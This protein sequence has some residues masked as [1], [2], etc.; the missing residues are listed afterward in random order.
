MAYTF[1]A[2]DGGAAGNSLV[3]SDRF[4]DALAVQR[5]AR[6]AERRLLLPS[7]HLVADRFDADAPTRETFD[8]VKKV[9]GLPF[10]NTDYR[11]FARWPSYWTAAWGDL[12]EIAGG[13]PHEAICQAY[14]DNLAAAVIDRLPNPGGLSSEAL[15][16][17]AGED[18]AGKDGAGEVMEMCRL[19]QWLLPGLAVNVAYLKRQI[20]D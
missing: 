4:G 18:A 14:H 16:G 9:L 2:A 3:E 6:D 17:A 10:V 12:R 20:K 7:D 5:A 1:I 15:I 13:P 8:D 11:A 19:F